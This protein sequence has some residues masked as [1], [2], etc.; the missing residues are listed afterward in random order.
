MLALLMLLLV[1]GYLGYRYAYKAGRNISTEEATFVIPA[2]TLAAEYTANPA[3]ADTKYLNKTIEVK[4]LVTQVSDSVVTL[5]SA[6]F[7]S[8]DRLPVNSSNKTISI[9]GRCIG[10]DELFSEVKLDQCSIKK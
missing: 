9:K 10:Y 7:C 4:G 6:V 2:V 5:D 8:F 3:A 1:A